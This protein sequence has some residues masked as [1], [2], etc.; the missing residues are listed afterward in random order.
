VL[1]SF[2]LAGNFFLQMNEHTASSGVAKEGLDLAAVKEQVA[3]AKKDVKETEAKVAAAEAKVA[4]AEAKVNA[5]RQAVNQAGSEE[6][7]QAKI[8]LQYALD[9]R[10]IALDALKS[11]QEAQAVRGKILNELL[12]RQSGGMLSHALCVLTVVIDFYHF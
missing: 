9:T 7:A 8:E 2:Q 10:K 1:A 3:E 12:L 5:A 4:A 11:S 6:K